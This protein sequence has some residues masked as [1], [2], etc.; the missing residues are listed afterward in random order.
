ML[1]EEIKQNT[2]AWLEIRKGKM[3]ASH[4]AVIYNFGLDFT[5]TKEDYEQ[6]V[7]YC[8]EKPTKP[9]STKIEKLSLFIDDNG[10]F[11]SDLYFNKKESGLQTY[12]YSLMSEYYSAGIK[13]NIT[14]EAMQIGT[15]REIEAKFL[16]NNLFNADI[17]DVGFVVGSEYYGCSPDGRILENKLVEIKCPTDETFFKLLFTQK[18]KSEYYAQMQ[19][20]MLIDNKALCDY[21]VYN[22]N[23]EKIY[24][25]KEV[26]KDDD[27]IKYLQVGLDVGSKQIQKLHEA[28][29]KIKKEA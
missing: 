10:N 4:A 19:M 8:Q 1:S 23:F 20:Q 17:E 12:V 9:L 18:I 11:C 16:Y 21:F 24:F 6:T 5:K 25:N 13:T 3:T 2:P 7:I 29:S 27:F 26:K 28:Y 15:E 22:P 14:N